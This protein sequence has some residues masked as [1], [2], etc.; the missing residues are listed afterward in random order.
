VLGQK[1]KPPAAA[2][3]RS[4]RFRLRSDPLTKRSRWRVGC[5]ARPG[6][7]RIGRVIETLPTHEAEAA[8]S[9]A[10]RRPRR[11]GRPNKQVPSVLNLGTLPYGCMRDWDFAVFMQAFSAHTL[12]ARADSAKSQW[13]LTHV[14]GSPIPVLGLKFSPESMGRGFVL[15]DTRKDIGGN[16]DILSYHPCYHPYM[17]NHGYP[18]SIVCGPTSMWVSS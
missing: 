18:R 14:L 1:R 8:W 7:T 5:S 2:H 17:L 16:V 9:C 11:G 6:Q 13:E 12:L 4:K 10:P 3:W 15:T